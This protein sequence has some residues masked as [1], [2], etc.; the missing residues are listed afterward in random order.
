MHQRYT[1]LFIGITKIQITILEIVT[2]S[3]AI[4]EGGPEQSPSER[5]KM[6]KIK[7]LKAQCF[8]LDPPFSREDNAL[9]YAPVAPD[10]PAYL[11]QSTILTGS[12]V[13]VILAPAIVTTELL[14]T[15][16]YNPATTDRT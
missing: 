7:V 5:C 3:V 10:R 4:I 11:Q 1:L 13:V 2:M 8:H 6:N 15:P 12:Q 9:Q 16:P 14:V